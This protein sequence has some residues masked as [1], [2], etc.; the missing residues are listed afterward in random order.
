MRCGSAPLAGAG[1]TSQGLSAPRSFKVHGY[2]VDSCSVAIRPGYWIALA[3]AVVL[4]VCLGVVGVVL[5]TINNQQVQHNDSAARELAAIR[6][7]AQLYESPGDGCAVICLRDQE[8]VTVAVQTAAH[9]L[10]IK[11]AIATTQ[12]GY[13][14]APEA[15]ITATF[16]GV[17]VTV[18]A[19][20]QLVYPSTVDGTPTEVTYVEVT[21]NPSSILSP[22]SQAT[23]SP[24]RNVGATSPARRTANVRRTRRGVAGCDL[25]WTANLRTPCEQTRH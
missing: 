23:Q 20:T 13:D 25:R 9:A 11:N 3:L 14:G 1:I 16:D 19:Y 15:A 21:L 2:A 17:P 24:S 12:P 4:F 7:P 22:R 10:G 8:P 6:W 5:R 18:F